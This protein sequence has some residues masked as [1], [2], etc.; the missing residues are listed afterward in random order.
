M[1]IMSLGKKEKEQRVSMTFENGM[2]FADCRSCS[3]PSDLGDV[4]CVKCISEGISG[5][6]TPLRLMMRKQNDVEY[7]EGVISIL[8]DISKI[9]SLTSA[10][11]SEKTQSRCKGRQCSIPKNASDIWDSFPD[12]RFD[13]MRL[14]AER[15]VI[16]EGGCEECLWRTMGFIDRAE[17]MFSDVRKK[18]AKMAFRLTEV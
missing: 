5:N 8:S 15:A 3:G 11:S 13:I 12:P 2:L 10:A 14:D 16:G 1:N 18:A 4:G 17:T 6:G 9:G 7:S